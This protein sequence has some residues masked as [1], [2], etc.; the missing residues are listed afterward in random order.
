MI[1]AKCCEMG[2]RLSSDYLQ[3]MNRVFVPAD[4]NPA[5]VARQCVSPRNSI[6]RNRCEIR[7]KFTDTRAD[8]DVNDP[9]SVASLEIYPKF[10]IFPPHQ[11]L[12]S[13]GRDFLCR[14][15]SERVY[16]REPHLG[17][18]YIYF[19]CKGSKKLSV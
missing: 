2:A 19:S 12:E 4:V 5:A 1:S 9:I 8:V 11:F 3:R 14:G 17:V 13:V 18:V 15:F 16:R 7:A 10:G 6:I